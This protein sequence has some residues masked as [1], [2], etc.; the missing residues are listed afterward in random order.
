[1]LLGKAVSIIILP[2][3]AENEKE[4]LWENFRKS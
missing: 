3:T 4:F 2:K 1:M